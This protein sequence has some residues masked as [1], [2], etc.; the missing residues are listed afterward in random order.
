MS[1][2]LTALA[3]SKAAYDLVEP[4]VTGIFTRLGWK[5]DDKRRE[6]VSARMREL[7]RQSRDVLAKS[8][9]DQAG[10]RLQALIDNL[11]E[12]LL[13]AGLPP[14]DA[15]IFTDQAAAVVVMVAFG[16]VEEWFALRAKIPQLEAAI[17]EEKS[18]HALAQERV[19]SLEKR[20]ATNTILGAVALAIAICTLLVVV[21]RR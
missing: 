14:E 9:P 10:P 3:T 13:K 21:M 16:S 20:I 8:S 7:V 15:Q 12:D 17:I 5:K 1:S 4:L 2:L 11:R 18:A 6:A 19:A